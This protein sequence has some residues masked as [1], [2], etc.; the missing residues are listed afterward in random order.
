MFDKKMPGVL[1]F[2][3]CDFSLWV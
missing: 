3:L 1:D 2:S